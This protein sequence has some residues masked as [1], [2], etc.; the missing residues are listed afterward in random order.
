EPVDGGPKSAEGPVETVRFSDLIQEIKF[1]ESL[2]PEQRKALEGLVLKNYQAFGLD[3][4]LGEIP[5]KAEIPLKPGYKPI[6]LPPFPTSPAKREVIDSQMNTW[7]QQGVIEL[8]KSP[9]GAPGFIVY[10]NNK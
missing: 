3:D 1:S 8:S 7:I 2:N 4:R 6:S 5:A 10:R 9:W